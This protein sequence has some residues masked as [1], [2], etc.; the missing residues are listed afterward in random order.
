MNL[1]VLEATNT[2]DLEAIRLLRFHILRQPWNQSLESAGDDLDEIAV[3]AFIRNQAQEVVACGRLQ[4]NPEKIGQ[5]RYMA[6]ASDQQGKG[7]GARIVEHLE[8]KA[9]MMGLVKIELHARENAVEF[10]RHQGYTLC[11][12]SY[13]LWDI[14]QHYRMEKT[15]G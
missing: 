12:P 6:V 2:N 9:K 3:N 14:I 11:E 4:E 10:Y 8:Q 7:L 5:I 15:I 1:P 13:K